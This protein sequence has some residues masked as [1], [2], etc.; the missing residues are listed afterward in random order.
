MNKS[1]VLP[2]TYASFDTANLLA[3]YAAVITLAQPVAILRFINASNA[4]VKI[5]YDG[6]TNHDFILPTSSV[7]LDFQSDSAPNGFMA[8]I[9]KGT[10]ISVAGIAGV[11]LIYIT[12][13]Y[14][15]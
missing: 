6:V 1:F 7:T 15:S 3:G 13:Y 12:G 5:S 14:L 9:R 10:V 2:L 11:G 4:G 8:M